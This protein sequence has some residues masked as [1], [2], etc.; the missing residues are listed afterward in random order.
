MSGCLFN[1][2]PR[3]AETA[4]CFNMEEIIMSRIMGIDYG[5]RRVGVAMTDPSGTFSLPHSVIE[6]ESP[7]DA[8]LQLGRLVSDTGAKAIVIGRPIR[9]DGTVGTMATKVEAFAERLREVTGLSVRLWD[10]RL[11]TCEV[12]RFL[13]G[14]DMS[15]RR[16]KEVRDKLAANT[17]LQS[18][19]DASANVVHPDGF[20]Q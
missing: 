14:A 2:L 10:E 9:M 7:E 5:E 19:L 18:Y 11:T 4:T 6:V 13:L 15:R 12:E 3:L 17:I 1:N 20:P 16:R 8:L